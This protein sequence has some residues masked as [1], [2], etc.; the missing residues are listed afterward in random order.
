PATG[1]PYLI[2]VDA[3]IVNLASIFNRGT[4][5]INKSTAL[6]LYI[7]RAIICR[8]KAGQC[9]LPVMPS[10]E[11]QLHQSPGIPP[12]YHDLVLCDGPKS[13]SLTLARAGRV[14]FFFSYR[15]FAATNHEPPTEKSETTGAHAPDTMPGAPSLL[16]TTCTAYIPLAIAHRNCVRLPEFTRKYHAIYLRIEHE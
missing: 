10:K 14:A 13:T 5:F 3:S 1:V 8:R 12:R 11:G 6:S 7:Y 4:D 9:D 15:N 16:H 2:A